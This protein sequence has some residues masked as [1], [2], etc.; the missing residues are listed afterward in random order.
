ETGC[1]RVARKEYQA[2]LHNLEVAAA[3]FTGEG[4]RVEAIRAYLYLVIACHALG[5]WSQAVNYLSQLFALV[6][7]PEARHPLITTGREVRS[8]LEALS[9]KWDAGPLVAEFLEQIVH[10][11]TR[12]P[13]IRRNLRR[14]AMSVAFAPPKM[15]IRALGRMQ[16]RVNDQAVTNADW[17]TQSCRDLFFLILSHPEGLTKEDVGAIFWPDA[18]P[19]ELKLRFKN[20]VYRV[21]HAAGKDAITFQED[22]YYFNRQIDYE[23][24]VEVFLREIGLA[25]QALDP[26]DCLEHYLAALKQYKGPYLPEIEEIWVIAERERLRQVYLDALLKVAELYQH[27]KQYDTAISYC[28]RALKEDA[29]LEAAHRLAMRIYAEMGSRASLVRQ[30]EECRRALLEEIDA[31]PSAQTQE[32]FETLMR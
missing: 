25:G 32:L 17:Q 2:S 27:E 5:N 8:Q 22:Y 30:Y 15:I 4:H 12:V 21:R 26:G 20:N 19:A 24:D 29:C 10:F 14:R 23:Y 7:D 1:L 16:L 18:S 28:Q 6:S 9:G 11:E 13:Q 3:F 31:D